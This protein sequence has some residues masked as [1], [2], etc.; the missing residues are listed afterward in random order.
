MG[1][2]D[3]L[4]RT[5]AFIFRKL[6]S[7]LLAEPF[8][9]FLAVLATVIATN[10]LTQEVQF[11]HIAVEPYF[12]GSLGLFLWASFL[13]IGNVLTLVGVSKI[14]K[15][16]LLG[17]RV[18]EITGLSIYALSFSYYLYAYFSVTIAP[19][20]GSVRGVVYQVYGIVEIVSLILASLIRI[21]VLSSPLTALS[22]TRVERIKLIK[23]QLSSTSLN[24]VLKDIRKQ[25]GK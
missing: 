21:V 15:V 11:G 10:L 22:V 7:A 23:E 16:S 9:F 20:P 17:M 14:G 3:S 5:G 24:A 12:H 8:E 13:S 19:Q 6:P 1:I 18:M 25:D 2:K 4:V